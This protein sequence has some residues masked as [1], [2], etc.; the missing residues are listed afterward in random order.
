MPSTI[1]SAYEF[2]VNSDAKRCWDFLASLE[3]IGSCIPGCES[4][5][6]IDDKTAVFA[7]KVSV[8]YVSKTF[9]MKARFVEVISESHLSFSGDGRDAEI[10]GT[11]DLRPGSQMGVTSVR[12]SLQIRPVSAVGRTAAAFFGRDLVKKQAESFANCVK[13]KLETAGVPS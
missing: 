9:E 5:T 7:V 2:Q 13:A 11:L 3:N 4:V 8:G 6:P 12:Y 1:D 10:V